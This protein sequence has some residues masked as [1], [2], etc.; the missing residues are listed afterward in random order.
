MGRPAYTTTTETVTKT[1]YTL[2]GVRVVVKATLDGRY[3]GVVRDDVS[4]IA[5]MGGRDAAT[6]GKAFALAL[7]EALDSGVVWWD[8][9]DASVTQFMLALVA[10]MYGV[11]GDLALVVEMHGVM[12]DH[13]NTGGGT[14]CATWVSGNH[15]AVM[16]DDDC[17]VGFY[18]AD[19]WFNGLPD[20]STPEPYALSDSTDFGSALAAIGRFLG[21]DHL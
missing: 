15:V 11:M 6:P 5:V 18:V 4:A 10:E 19:E 13:E 9:V 7:S 20:G 12:G 14:V 17:T 16:G 3:F 21:R 8:D 1:T 2:G